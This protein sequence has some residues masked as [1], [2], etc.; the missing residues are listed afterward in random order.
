MTNQTNNTPNPIAT[1]LQELTQE[2]NSLKAEISRIE[3]VIL[4]ERLNAVEEA[5]AQNRLTQYADL[6]NEEADEDINKLLNPHCD[7][8]DRCH[9][10][11][12]THLTKNLKIAKTL[13]PKPA[14]TDLENRITQIGTQIEK[15]KGTQCENC[16][17]R[18]E[19]KLKREKR[20]F[21]TVV[22]VEKTQNGD[23]EAAVDIP[24]IVENLLEPLANPVRL[25]ILLSLYGG[26]KNFSKLSGEMELKGGHLIFHLKKLLDAKLV[27]Q[28]D[29][30]GDYII[31][32]KGVD[33]AKKIVLLGTTTRG[34]G[35]V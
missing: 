18:F 23:Q 17:I 26:K 4:K 2:V 29:N 11:F 24:F 25:R 22:L 9:Q 30:K 10:Y 14:L 27:T 34:Q 8:K 1:A 6:L 13:G 33:A 5:L 32:P 3:N 7:K 12:K 20:A 28:E 21:Q 16:Q 31:T 35:A 19:K 15:S